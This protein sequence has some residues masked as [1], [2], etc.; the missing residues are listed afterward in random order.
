[1][2]SPQIAWISSD[3]PPDAFPEI[4]AA[5]E[6]PDG[7]LAAG[8]DLS[9]ERLL[10]AYRHGIFPWFD[11]GQPILWWSPN[12]RCVLY[13]N[14]L[15]LSRRTLRSL[16]KSDFMIKVNTAF[17]DVVANCAAQREGQDGTWINDDMAAAY[18]DLHEHHW[19]HSIEVW[20]NN[21]LVGGLY[22][23]AID[24]VFFGESMFSRESNAS[25][26]AMFALCKMLRKSNVEMLDCQVESPHLMSLGASLVP[27]SQ[28]ASSLQ[29]AC[30]D[31]VPLDSWPSE[32]V[33]IADILAGNPSSALQ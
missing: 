11:D 6:T 4:N 26:A 15:R 17:S 22:G 14:D 23:I 31:Y 5:F 28:F 2:K 10:Y 13:T 21:R 29:T 20:S 12:P 32:P 25:K 16:R 3:D 18:Q 9:S 1:M 27:R 7:L 24:K 8:G 19:A 33:K 30:T